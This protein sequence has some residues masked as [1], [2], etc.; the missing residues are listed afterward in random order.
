MSISPAQLKEARQ[1]VGWSL[2]VVG[3]KSNL[4][5]STISFFE[6]GRRRPSAPIVS[7]I[8]KAFEVAGVEFTNGGQSG[9]KLRGSEP[10]MTDGQEPIAIPAWVPLSL[11]TAYSDIAARFGEEEA[12]SQIRSRKRNMTPKELQHDAEAAR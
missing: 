2:S 11:R 1:L 7:K 3:G 6:T 5:A 10:K 4:S 9:V 12:A 8:R